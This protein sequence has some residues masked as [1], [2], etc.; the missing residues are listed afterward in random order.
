MLVALTLERVQ[1][2]HDRLSLAQVGPNTSCAFPF[3]YAGRLHYTC[4]STYM[5]HNGSR[6]CYTHEAESARQ[7]KAEGDPAAEVATS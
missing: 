3:A 1:Q 7:C 6:W 2:I 4:I 5:H